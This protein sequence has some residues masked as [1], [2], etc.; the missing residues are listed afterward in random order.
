MIILPTVLHYN[1]AL[2]K[3]DAISVSYSC[4]LKSSYQDYTMKC[5]LKNDVI[6]EA[7]MKKLTEEIDYV[8]FDHIY[9]DNID[10]IRPIIASIGKVWNTVNA[11]GTM[12]TCHD[13]NN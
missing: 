2:L 13:E 1:Q 6:K 9:N 5:L 10:E 12:R 8:N 3:S 4:T 11:H 7:S